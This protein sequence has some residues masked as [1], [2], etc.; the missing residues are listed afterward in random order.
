MR[1]KIIP[2]RASNEM[3]R[4]Q[5]SNRASIHKAKARVATKM[6]SNVTE[7]EIERL[8]DGV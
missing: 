4:S 5:P 2:V 7:F 3:T 1:P 8:V 6:A